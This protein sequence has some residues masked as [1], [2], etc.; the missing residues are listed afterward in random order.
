MKYG[1]A[2]LLNA[3]CAL[4]FAVWAAATLPFGIGV[5]VATSLVWLAASFVWVSAAYLG[6]GA[7]AF[8]KRSDGRLRPIAIV[9][10]APYLLLTWGIWHAVRACSREPPWHRVSERLIVGRRLLPNE[11]PGE[12]AN[13]VDLTAEFVEPKA[14]LDRTS[15][16][17]FPI[18]DAGTAGEA[19][20]AELARTIASLPGLTYLHCA[21]G[22]GRTGTV[23]A[24]VLVAGGEEMSAE[25]A[26]QRLRELRPG[27]DVNERQRTFLEQVCKQLTEECERSGGVSQRLT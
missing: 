5:V 21:L 19:S 6:L 16:F 4:A 15:Y 18:L 13:V 9:A 23:A 11:L 12:V 1:V 27:L 24:A 25:G 14:I 10:L 17:S 20:V 26:L 7:K 22:H 8:G 3:G 2:F